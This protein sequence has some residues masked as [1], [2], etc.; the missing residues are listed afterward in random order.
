MYVASWNSTQVAVKLFFIRNK[1]SRKQFITEC[2]L[3]QRLYHPNIVRVFGVIEGS[4]RGGIV[5]QLCKGNV[6]QLYPELKWPKTIQILRET[7]SAMAYPH[8]NHVYHRDLKPQ[9]I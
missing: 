4:T 3:L 9:N 1:D 6:E 2:A 7:C 5:M 8:K